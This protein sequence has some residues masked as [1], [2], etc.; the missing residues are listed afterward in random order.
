MYRRGLFSLINDIPYL[1]AIDLDKEVL[2]EIE[3]EIASGIASPDKRNNYS[4]Y[5]ISLAIIE[6]ASFYLRQRR[7][8]CNE[9]DEDLVSLDE[10]ESRKWWSSGWLPVD[11]PT[12]LD[13]YQKQANPFNPTQ[14]A[15]KFPPPLYWYSTDERGQ[16]EQINAP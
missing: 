6:D 14:K 11:W 7:I 4:L 5:L 9:C 1:H 10:D 16:V 3:Y 13:T 8:W 2:D 15:N 12:G